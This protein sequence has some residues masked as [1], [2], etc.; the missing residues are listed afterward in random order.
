M[1]TKNYLS[2]AIHEKGAYRLKSLSHSF[3]FH[4]IWPRQSPMP[5]IRKENKRHS[6]S[7]NSPLA[8]TASLS[9]GAFPGG[10]K[11]GGGLGSF[12]GTEKK[13]YPS[14][15]TVT[16]RL[17]NTGQSDHSRIRTVNNSKLLG[18]TC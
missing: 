9:G 14:E 12:G 6:L 10:G 11:T 18:F 2:A 3:P 16:V 4:P 13:S 8:L 7:M 17:L 1:Q 5:K 15:V